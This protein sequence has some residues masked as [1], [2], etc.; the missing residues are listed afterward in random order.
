MEEGG[1]GQ[2]GG[3]VEQCCEQ[4]LCN[5][6]FRVPIGVMRPKDMLGQP[7]STLSCLH[8]LHFLTPSHPLTRVRVGVKC[9]R[10]HSPRGAQR[11]PFL[12]THVLPVGCA[13][14]RVDRGRVDR[15]EIV[16]RGG[17]EMV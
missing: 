1:R 5:T 14:G 16:G 15:G 12:V 10:V 3:R 17:E 7:S 9:D 13:E 11:D 6:V 2:R 8:P 4:Y